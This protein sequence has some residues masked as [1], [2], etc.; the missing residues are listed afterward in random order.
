MATRI[1]L[2]QEWTLGERIGGGGF[3][4]VYAA[5]SDDKRAAIKLVPKTPGA[6]RELLFVDVKG[7]RNVV[8]IIDSGVYEDSWA[9]VMP[10][11]DK[12]LRQH[13]DDLK[14]PLE[15][16]EAIAILVDIATAL[17]DIDTRIVHRDLKPE[18]VL[19]LGGKWCLADFGISRYAEASTA[20]D[21]QKFALSPPYAAPERWRNERATSATDIYSLGIIAVE[22][23]T[24]A[25]PFKGPAIED[26]R[27]QH[28]HQ[29]A[30]DIASAPTALRAMISECLYKAAGARPTA[31]NV[32]VRLRRVG[33]E[34][35]L[36]GAAKL[37]GSNLSEIGRRSESERK[38][39]E[40]RSRAE[41]RAELVRTAERSLKAIQDELFAAIKE[42][43]PAAQE[44]TGRNGGR[45][46]ALG[47][48]QIEFFDTTPTA[49]NPWEWEAPSFDVVAHGGL[50]VRIPTDQYGYGGR[51]HSL[52][53]CDAQVLGRYQWYELAFMILPMVPKATRFRPFGLDP[54]QDV[55]RRGIRT[56]FSG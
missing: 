43:A 9:L 48:A 47:S 56:P 27:E 33:K 34:Q 41:G 40:E 8:P 21:T 36:S 30:P 3:G 13:L 2:K 45:T 1:K 49:D 17:S 18:N 24:G 4:K 31:A 54:G 50:I 28:L 37:Q 15:T 38:Q 6:D 23:L 14:N 5:T 10:R 26:Y 12:S 11:A 39:S 53:F 35:L 16:P 32:L 7:A 51:S 29:E 52:W 19:L 20:P 44:T 22:L 46:L 55:F 42:A 25:R